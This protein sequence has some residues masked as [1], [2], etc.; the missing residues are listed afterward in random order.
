MNRKFFAGIRSS[1]LLTNIQIKIENE[2]GLLGFDREI[3]NFKPHITILR[4]KG[5]EDFNIL[6]KF[7]NKKLIILLRSIQSHW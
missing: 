6:D 2:F 4:I 5:M 1:E 7:V 3:R